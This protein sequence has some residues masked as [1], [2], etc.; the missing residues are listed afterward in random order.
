[1]KYMIE[2]G[3]KRNAY[4]S[5]GIRK[6]LENQRFSFRT[7]EGV[8]REAKV[9]TQD[10]E[11]AIA[12]HSDEIVVLYRR[13]TNGERLVTTRSHYKKKASIKEKMMGAILNCVY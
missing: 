8:A 10:V 6:A 2:R 4:I 5:A 1:M 9:T 13:G 3:K 11:V 7:I 12:N